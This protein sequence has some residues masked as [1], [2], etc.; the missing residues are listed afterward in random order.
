[1]NNK[2]KK[3]QKIKANK[4][5]Y[6]KCPLCGFE[7]KDSTPEENDEERIYTEECEKCGKEFPVMMIRH[8]EYEFI[9]FFPKDVK[10]IVKI[11]LK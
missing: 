6:V 7:F 4:K 11:Q 1:M 5:E 3:I 8:V 9:S 2:P 10:K